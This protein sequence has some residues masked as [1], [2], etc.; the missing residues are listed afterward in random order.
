MV[1]FDTLPLIVRTPVI[2]GLRCGD[3]QEGYYDLDLRYG[4][5]DTESTDLNGLLTSANNAQV[6]VLYDEIDRG[7]GQQWVHRILLWPYR[8]VCIVFGRLGLHLEPR[9]SRE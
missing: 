7:E 4:D 3:L 2:M 8:E 6:E 9:E 5:I 1:A